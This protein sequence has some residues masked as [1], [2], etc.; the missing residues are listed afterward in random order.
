MA[1]LPEEE[2]AFEHTLLVVREVSVFKIPPRTTSGGYKC[3]E[4]LQ[5]DKIWTGRLRVVSCGDRCEIRLEDPGSGDLF[6]A[7]FVLP[8]QRDS[9]VETVLDS[10]RY[11]VL[12]IEDGRG[13]HAFVGLGFGERNEAFDFNVALSD[14]EKYVKREQDKETGGEEADDSQIDIHPAVN[15]RLKEGETIRINVKNKPSTGSGMLSSAGLSGG[16]TEK[17]K[18]SMLLAPPPGA[19]GKLRSPLPPPPNDSASARMS[20]GPNAGT[21]ASKEPTK[22]SIDPFS[23][24]SALERSLPSSTELGQTKSTGA[25]WAAF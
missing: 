8:G 9:A 14:H 17:P 18:A 22:K 19:T 23:D 12:R 16:A 10:S 3:G 15:R 1:S 6:A 25:G 13:K 5:T 2:E 20:S 4:W 21:R 7:C 11:F 24:I